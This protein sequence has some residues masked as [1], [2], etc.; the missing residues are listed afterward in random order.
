MAV[1]IG[2]LTMKYDDFLLRFL[3][4]GDSDQLYVFSDLTE[5]PGWAGFNT[6][7]GDGARLAD[8]S[9][10]TFAAADLSNF[11]GT[12]F[13]TFVF[14][15]NHSLDRD[16]WVQGHVRKIVRVPEPGALTMFGLGLT[17]LAIAKRFRRRK[18][19]VAPA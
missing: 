3:D 5:K 18:K 4:D 9:L 12:V 7:N 1:T 15:P 13:D 11:S 10:A 14:G 19:A 6:G 16:W 8:Y 17:A 2:S